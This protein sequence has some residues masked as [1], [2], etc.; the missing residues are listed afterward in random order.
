MSLTQLFSD[1]EHPFGNGDENAPLTDNWD[2]TPSQNPF[3]LLIPTTDTKKLQQFLSLS[4]DFK[5]NIDLLQTT[6]GTTDP[7]ITNLSPL[8]NTL[9]NL[10]V[11][12]YQIDHILNDELTLHQDDVEWVYEIYEKLQK[13]L[14]D[15]QALLNK[16]TKIKDN[17]EDDDDDDDDN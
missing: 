2:F 4:N 15:N 8:Q 12:F 11:D 14:W 1:N 10:N 17:I 6:L 16:L 3:D 7:T 13:Q 9:D 5:T